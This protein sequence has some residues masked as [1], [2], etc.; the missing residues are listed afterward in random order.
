MFVNNLFKINDDSGIEMSFDEIKVKT[1]RAAQ[2]LQN[3]GYK[4]KQVFGLIVKNSYHVAP[5]F[6][7]SIAIGCQLSTL[8][9][10]FGRTELIHI[11]NMTKPVL[12][13]CD[14]ECVDLLDEC[15]KE[16][17]IQAKIFT[18]GGSKGNSEP[19]ENLFKETHKETQF[20]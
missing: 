7:A 14:V 9:T 2:N 16:I 5:I 10:S 13:F 1:I 3:L 11:L 20:M 19:I 8:D 18:F 17:E 15:L 12:L 6:F 4:P